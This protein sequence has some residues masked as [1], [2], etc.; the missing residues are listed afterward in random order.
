MEDLILKRIGGLIAA[1][2]GIQVREQDYRN[3]SDKLW[4][5]IKILGLQS[6]ED[7]YTLLWQELEA[8]VDAVLKPDGAN[9]VTFKRTEWEELYSIVTINESYFFRDKNQFQL[10]ANKLLPEI[11]QHKQS[12]SQ[13]KTG[14]TESNYGARKPSLRIWSAGCSTGEELYSI[15]MML[16]EL[17]FPWQQWDTLLIGTDISKTAIEAAQKGMYSQWS[18][19]QI[20]ATLRNQYF[21]NHHHLFQI[22]DSI[23]QKV[24][25]VHGN[26]LKDIFP[27][28]GGDLD[29]I[30]LILCRNVFIYLDSHAI[31][32]II[33]KFYDTL[34]HQGYLITGHTE[35]Y[36]QDTSQFQ[37]ISFPESVIYRRRNWSGIM[38]S[39]LAPKVSTSKVQLPSVTPTKALLVEK[40]P[41]EDTNIRS[42]ASTSARAVANLSKVSHQTSIKSSDQLTTALQEAE[43]LL[44]QKANENAILKAEKI[45]AA[46]PQCDAAV[47]IA[48]HAC[49]NLGRYDEAKSLCQRVIQ[50][51]PLSVDMY[52]L[53]AQIAEEQ[54]ESE[55]TKNYLRKIIYLDPN[56]V[57]AY[58]DLAGIYEREKQPDKTKKMQAYALTLLDK[59]PADTVLDAH[60]G[61]TV[62]EW[63]NHLNRQT[64][65]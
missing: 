34:S 64:S 22:N 63:K 54:N 4:K 18:F 47:K 20:P 53:L 44:Q 55:I 56:F 65:P 33:H 31:G 48:A 7:Y 59:L 32:K 29:N 13:L 12:L 15:A 25:F 19:R 46:Y 3:L 14:E 23:R 45:F 35:L 27:K 28:S 57:K 30:D 21:H 43:R 26:L 6:L 24:K 42:T 41:L 50:R 9:G 38:P 5:R 52:Y 1:H 16:E 36:S 40:I 10:L 2:S 8:G 58:L 51:H 49:A 11:I 17:N 62:A 60:T 37:V 61:T 39:A